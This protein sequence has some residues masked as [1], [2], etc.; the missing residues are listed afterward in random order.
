MIVRNNEMRSFV[1]FCSC[2]MYYEF[3]IRFIEIIIS[4][5]PFYDKKKLSEFFI[6]FFFLAKMKRNG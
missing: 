1:N 3:M 4:K 5:F 6:F 2:F